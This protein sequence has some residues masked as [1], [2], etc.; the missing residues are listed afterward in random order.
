[1]IDQHKHCP[2]CGKPIPL[3]ETVC[4]PECAQILVEN[5]NRVQK[6]RRI[7]YIL[8][9]VFIIVWIYFVLRGK[10]F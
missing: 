3:S 7:L 5:R 10:W 4:S 9:A 1:M 8:F 6:T 2:A